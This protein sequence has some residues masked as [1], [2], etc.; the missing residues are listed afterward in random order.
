V[1]SKHHIEFVAQRSITTMQ[2]MPDAFEFKPTGRAQW[3]Q[4]QAWRF[5]G[6]C[7]ALKV[8]YEPVVTVNRHA[9]DAD[10]FLNRLLKQRH[11]L[12]DGFGEEAKTIL[13]GSEDY[14]ELMSEPFIN[15][16][17]C[18]AAELALNRRVIGLEVKVI[19][20]MRGAVVM[21]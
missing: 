12:F 5:L 14:F 11:A 13:I 4:Q 10:T 17:F 8:A 9:I 3:L 16:S 20:W 15:Q 18:F 1:K 19:P 7:G 6:W 21:P 2:V